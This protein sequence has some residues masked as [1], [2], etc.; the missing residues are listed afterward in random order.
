MLGLRIRHVCQVHG[1]GHLSVKLQGPLK[2]LATAGFQ[3][4]PDITIQGDGENVAILDAKWKR[5]DLGEPNSGVSSDDAYQMNAYASRYR[6]KRLALVY[7]ASGDCPPGKITEF[8]LMTEERPMLDVIAVDLRELAFGSGIPTGIGTMIPIERH[9][10]Q[11]SSQT[12]VYEA[13]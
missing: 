13:I 10:K 6:C 5:L 7:P 1:V 2:K 3:L 8:V 4:R 11:R 12:P 9:W